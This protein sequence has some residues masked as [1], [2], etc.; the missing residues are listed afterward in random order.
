MKVLSLGVAIVALA[1]ATPAA[2]QMVRAQDP[3]SLVKAMQDA[4]YQAKLGK[5]SQGDP[6]IESGIGGKPFVIFFYNCTA[7]KDCRTVQ[8]YTGYRK[9]GVSLEKINEHNRQ[10]RFGRAIIDGEGDPG[11]IMDVDLDDGGVSAELFI[12]NIE[13]WA[14][15]IAAYQKHLGI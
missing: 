1:A 15:A 4:G 2:A 6:K 10:Q 11:L 3:Q 13:F 12:D 7:N 9:K 5:D 8:F 14:G